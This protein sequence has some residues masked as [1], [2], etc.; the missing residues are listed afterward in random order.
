MKKIILVILL[1]C[2]SIG[3]GLSY[4]Q[5]KSNEADPFLAK[6]FNYAKAHNIKAL[7]GLR[8]QIKK[9]NNRNLTYAY[10]L[11]L[12]IASPKE[13][14]QQYIDNYPTDF[15]GLY[16]IGTQVDN[17]GLTPT[18]FYSIDSIG[19]IAEEGNEQAI[20]KIIFGQ[21]HSDGGGAELFTEYLEKV[22]NKHLQKT[23]KVFSRIDERQRKKAYVCFEDMGTKEFS[24][25]KNKL[26]QLKT[27]ATG[28]EL[29]IINEILNYNFG[30]CC[31]D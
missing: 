4:G 12:Y 11:A 1:F 16:F 2:L 6:M 29:K 5:E 14:K 7:E 22:L 3:L 27:T 25:I 15:D 30:D 13:Y 9:K 31:P 23:I 28:S 19:L 8:E 26:N 21:N 24:S 20:E 10:S 18:Y 17:K